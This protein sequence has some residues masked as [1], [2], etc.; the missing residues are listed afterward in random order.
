[1]V[2]KV[3]LHKAHPQSFCNSGLKSRTLTKDFSDSGLLLSYGGLWLKAGDQRPLPHLSDSRL[4]IDPR[5][6]K[7]RPDQIVCRKTANNS[8][9]FCGIVS[10]Q[11]GR[12]HC[13]LKGHRI[14][15]KPQK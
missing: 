2:I 1:M 14:Y 10:C 12:A 11:Q 7:E 5:T 6:W 4:K 13:A 3:E 9:L 15:V 8:G